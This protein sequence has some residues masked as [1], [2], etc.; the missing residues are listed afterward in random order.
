MDSDDTLVSSV[1]VAV[2]DHLNSL[3]SEASHKRLVASSHSSTDLVSEF[4]FSGWWTTTLAL[5]VSVS[6]F[7][8]LETWFLRRK[9]STDCPMVYSF[10]FSLENKGLGGF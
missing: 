8:S 7:A 4:E 3:P 9:Q 10:L 2:E 5:V 1:A 6:G